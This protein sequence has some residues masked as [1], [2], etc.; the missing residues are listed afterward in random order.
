VLGSAESE[1]VRLINREI[2]SQNCNLYD[3][4]ISALQTDG[5]MDKQLALAI[6]RSA[7]LRAV[8]IMLSPT[9]TILRPFRIFPR[10]A[11]RV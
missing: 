2:I 11:F 1:M 6:P 3:H 5:R 9:D 10:Q 7:R 8:K 4:D